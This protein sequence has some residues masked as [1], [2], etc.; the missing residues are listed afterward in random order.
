MRD[1][2]RRRHQMVLACW[3]FHEKLILVVVPFPFSTSGKN[4]CV[5]GKKKVVH[6]QPDYIHPMTNDLIHTCF[7]PH[8]YRRRRRC[9]H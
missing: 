2:Y 6:I 7:P 9:K 1:T 3:E 8:L 5:G 4:S